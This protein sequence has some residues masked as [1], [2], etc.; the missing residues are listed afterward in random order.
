LDEI[1]EAI[2]EIKEILECQGS[3]IKKLED[4]FTISDNASTEMARATDAIRFDHEAI[5]QRINKM[6]GAQYE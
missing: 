2:K 1:K 4:A 3:Q 6:G 5:K